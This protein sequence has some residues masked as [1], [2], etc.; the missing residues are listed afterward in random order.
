MANATRPCRLQQRQCSLESDESDSVTRQ[1]MIRGRGLFC[2]SYCFIALAGL[3]FAPIAH[4]K[5]IR[6]SLETNTIGRSFSDGSDLNN[7]ADL[8]LVSLDELVRSL[9]AGTKGT[10]SLA[11]KLAKGEQ[12]SF[13]DRL[14]SEVSRIIEQSPKLQLQRRTGRFESLA[15]NPE[16]GERF[17]CKHSDTDVQV[18]SRVQ[19]KGSNTHTQ[20]QVSHVRSTSYNMTELAFEW[21][22][23]CSVSVAAERYTNYLDGNFVLFSEKVSEGGAITDYVIAVIVADSLSVY[24]KQYRIDYPGR[25]TEYNPPDGPVGLQIVKINT[26]KREVVWTSGT[27][28]VSGEG[29]TPFRDGSRDSA[30]WSRYITSTAWYPA[31]SLFQSETDQCPAAARPGFYHEIRFIYVADSGNCRVR[32]VGFDDGRVVTRWG[33]G[34]CLTGAQSM[35]AYKDSAIDSEVVL[36]THIALAWA[37]WQF[38]IVV[39]RDAHRVRK[40][41][42]SQHQGL[43]QLAGSMT[44]HA[45]GSSNG[46]DGPG[47]QATFCR[48]DAVTATADGT[49]AIISEDVSPRRLRVLDFTITSLPGGDADDVRCTVRTLVHAPVA[50]THHL[51]TSFGGMALSPD[52]RYL[53]AGSWDPT[54]H[55]YDW[56][57]LLEEPRSDAVIIIS[58]DSGDTR[59][60][61][62]N[63]ALLERKTVAGVEVG[64]SGQVVVTLCAHARERVDDFPNI[65]YYIPKTSVLEVFVEAAALDSLACNSSSGTAAGGERGLATLL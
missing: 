33:Q 59:P 61:V 54:E 18:R 6:D 2:H 32:L 52:G 42:T 35:A 60:L 8:Q 36:G 49:R 45:C 19:F 7:V 20:P 51:L 39:D 15:V 44:E 47:E 22:G 1:P 3:F 25:N 34:G 12:G 48:P 16:S 56:Y 50:G 37:S 31:C 14:Q 62:F 41:V 65:D 38:L 5:P 63:D 10:L 43:S 24:R 4:G 11:Q 57:P 28:D 21:L 29:S 23:N 55:P 46:R 26:L 53:F 58:V 40:F 17:R 30:T 9:A 64:S 13:H 27:G